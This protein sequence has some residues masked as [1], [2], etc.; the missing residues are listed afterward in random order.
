MKQ[1]NERRISSPWRVFLLSWLLLSLIA[2]IWSIATPISAAPDEP[3]HIIKAASVARGEIRGANTPD[4]QRVEVPAYIAFADN[5]TC[6][7]YNPQ[8]TAECAP[9]EYGDTG[10]IVT[11]TTSAGLYNPTYYFLVGWPSLLFHTNAGVYA[12][13]AVS[14]MLSSLFLALAFMMVSGW[15]RPLFPLLGL[16]VAATPMVFFLDGVINP[17]SVETTATLAAFIGVV[18]IVLHPARSLV[19]QRSIIVLASAA[20]AVNMRGISPLWVAIALAAPFI[21]SSRD[22]MSV[23]LR[24]QSI[25]IAAIGILLF[26]AASVVWTLLSNSLGTG[27]STGVGA[28]PVAGVGYSPIHG[29]GQI[30]IATFDYGEGLVGIFGWLDTPVPSS[31]YFAWS[32][33]VGGLL[34]A[35][36]SVLRRWRL[37]FVVVLTSALVFL[38]AVVQGIYVK[39][40]GIVWQGRYALPIFVCVVFGVAAVLADRI[41]TIDTVSAKPFTSLVI[42]IWLGAQMFAFVIALKR[43]AVGTAPVGGA[44]W[45]GLF[46]RP[47]WSPPLVGTIGVTF[48]FCVVCAGIAL[49]AWLLAMRSRQPCAARHRSSPFG[50]LQ[51]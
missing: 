13:R 10:K 12:M 36:L 29:F 39:S 47:A 6:F 41:P 1:D 4:G 27:L 19:T 32:L 50:R 40:G 42:A 33:F 43:Y 15:K 34:L 23:L 9:L 11:T 48:A 7:A 16:L 26:T 38:P 45:R 22:Q 17:S 25:R 49:M 8:I 18:G 3:S 14:G 30:L 35:G 2:V 37:V 21:L 44:S 46:L 24:L 20:I 31:V 28:A 51:P 5:Q